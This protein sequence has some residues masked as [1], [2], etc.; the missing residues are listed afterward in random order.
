MLSFG[1][2]AAN[3]LH[4]NGAIDA[5]VLSVFARRDDGEPVYANREPYIQSTSTTSVTIVWNTDKPASTLLEYRLEG[6]TKWQKPVIKSQPVRQHLVKLTGLKP[7]SRYRYRVGSNGRLLSEAVFQTNKL[8][9]QAFVV[10]VW[11]DS[12]VGDKNQRR[13]AAQIEKNKPDLL[14]HTGDLIYNRGEW[15]NF[16]PNFFSIYQSTLKRVPFYGT[17]G[18]H[19]VRTQNGRPF[20]ENFVLPRNGPQGVEPE[21]NYAFDYAD[22]HWVVIDTNQSTST[23]RE[24]IVPW[25][26]QD[27]KRSRAK[28]KFAVFH[29]PPFSSGPHGDEKSVKRTLVPVFSRLGVDVVLNGHDH[30]YERFK[31]QNGVLYIVTGAGGAE[32]Y[33]RRTKRDISAFFDNKNWSFTR[34]DINQS[35]LRARQISSEGRVIDEWRLQK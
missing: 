24:R 35:T 23:L 10:A 9:G 30:S 7:A 13:L 3:V 28:W 2:V 16:D 5:K 15:R 18:N 34:L 29:H 14:V 1:F 17:L 25:L 31:P 33:A 12:G 21:R 11:G 32:R 26:E 4:Y 22:A 19:D 8:P 27:L 6:T 20:L